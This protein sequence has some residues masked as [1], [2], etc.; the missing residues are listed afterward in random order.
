MGEV[1][2]E[3]EGEGEGVVMGVGEL[4]LLIGAAGCNLISE[5]HSEG[6]YTKVNITIYI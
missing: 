2:G 1:E 6:L 5:E 4:A 3:G